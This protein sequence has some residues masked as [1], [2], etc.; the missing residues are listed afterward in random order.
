VLYTVTVKFPF[1]SILPRGW[2]LRAWMSAAVSTSL[3]S[4]RGRLRQPT[5]INVWIYR[6]I[7]FIILVVCRFI[8]LYNDI[9]P[10]Y[11]IVL[12]LVEKHLFTPKTLTWNETVR[13]C[14]QP[15]VLS[16]QFPV[17]N[18]AWADR[19]THPGR[20]A[21]YTWPVVVRLADRQGHELPQRNKGLLIVHACVSITDNW[22]QTPTH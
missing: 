12:Q 7:D 13:L 19:G 17:S 11:V 15:P 18:G 16:I 4:S 8:Y 3:T 9:V 2:V 14:I 1:R 22:I 6:F 5:R 21:M 20:S 10:E